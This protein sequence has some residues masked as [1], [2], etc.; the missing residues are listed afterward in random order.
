[1]PVKSLFLIIVA[2]V[3]TAITAMRKAKGRQRVDEIE[4]GTVAL[5]DWATVKA[6]LEAASRT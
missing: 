4:A 6:R 1:M 5:D 2:V 3:G